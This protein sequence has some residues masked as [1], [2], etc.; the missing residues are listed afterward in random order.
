V[1]KPVDETYPRHEGVLVSTLNTRRRTAVSITS[2]LAATA[3][4][5]SACGGSGSTTGTSTGS[6][7][8]SSSSSSVTV[9]FSPFNQS[10]EALIGLGKGLTGYLQS[11]GAKTLVADPKN[12]SQTQI[13]QIQAWIQNGQTQAIWLLS[14]NTG[15]M[16]NT[17][18]LAQS[19]GIPMVANGTPDQYGFNGLQPGLSFSNIDYAS[20]GGAV[21]KAEGTCL[22]QRAGSKHEVILLTPAPGVAEAAAVAPFK[23]ALTAADP[24][25]TIVTETAEGADPLT[26]QQH[27]SSAL[28][29]HPNAVGV[30]SFHD[31]GAQG[32]MVA[33]QQAGKDSSKACL[34]NAGGAT[35]NLDAVKSGKLYAVVALQFADD[36]KQTADLL[37]SMVKDP[38]AVGKQLLTPIKTITK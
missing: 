12:S 18:Q 25:A 22:T 24:Q 32:A 7:G 6:S 28:Q 23:A 30:V 17:L 38:K 4:A 16:K 10:A 33:F 3:L 2:T 9:G 14:L 36:L 13:Q 35:Q 11:K 19:K 31:E 29:A 20:Y 21:G 26:A 5:V 37:M 27:T 34:V 8:S 1:C 15:A